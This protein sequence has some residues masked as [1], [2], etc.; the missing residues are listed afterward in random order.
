MITLSL[1]TTAGIL[2]CALFNDE[3]LVHKLSLETE[4]QQ[5]NLMPAVEKLYKEADINKLDTSLICVD[6]GPGA[7]TA[8]RIG[9]SAAKTLAHALNVP[10]VGVSVLDALYKDSLQ[11]NSDEDFDRVSLVDARRTKL[12][13][14]IF[15]K[16]GTKKLNLDLK[17]DEILYF[18]KES[19]AC[20]FAGYGIGDYARELKNKLADKKV[21][22][23]P[24]D[25]CRPD[26]EKIGRLGI[27]EFKCGTKHDFHSLVPLYIRDSDN[28]T[29]GK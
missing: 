6:K 2:S 5:E 15:Y 9:V 25:L 29:R 18:L 13:L 23:V 24:E 22:F 28:V 3:V 17:V 10:V 12:F 7:F 21:I 11:F 20:I 1:E 26:A 19:T 8:L 16:D 14:S 4:S 27:N